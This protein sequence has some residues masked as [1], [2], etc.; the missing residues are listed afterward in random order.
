MDNRLTMAAPS[1][2]V[3]TYLTGL[4]SE[5]PQDY[6]GYFTGLIGAGLELADI[7]IAR[8]PDP[9][10]LL[11]QKYDFFEPRGINE[12]YTEVRNFFD[13]MGA[14]STNRG[15]FV[16]PK[17][18]GF[19]IE[20]QEAMVEFFTRH[21]GLDRPIKVTKPERLPSAQMNV[22]AKGCVGLI[23][24]SRSGYELIADRADL[25]KKKRKRK[26]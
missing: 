8:A 15:L 21:S 3:S 19:T 24:G 1:C 11:G 10:L 16:G 18:H 17:G 9:V 20:N 13:N 2:S 14:P 4:E 25:L 5:L 26:D 12:T 23:D 22:T 6:E 7:F